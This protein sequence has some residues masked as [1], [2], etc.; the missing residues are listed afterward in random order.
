MSGNY[1][2]IDPR[3]YGIHIRSTPRASISGDTNNKGTRDK[4][5]D[6]SDASH[7]RSSGT[8]SSSTSSTALDTT[9]NP[10]QGVTQFIDGTRNGELLSS[11]TTTTTPTLSSTIA[12]H[13]SRREPATT[14]QQ[15]KH[16]QRRQRL[17]E[18]H[19]R[20]RRERIAKKVGHEIDSDGEREYWRAVYDRSMAESARREA[21]SP[22]ARRQED[23]ESAAKAFRSHIEPILAFDDAGVA[24]L[25]HYPLFLLQR[26]PESHNGAACRLPHCFDRIAPGQYRIAVSP[27]SWDPRGPDHYHVK[28]FE[29]LLDLSSLH[30]VA[31]FEPDRRKHIPDHGACCI[32]EEYMSRWRRRLRTKQ[33]S[34]S[35]TQQHETRLQLPH[36]PGAEPEHVTAESSRTQTESAAAANDENETA[37]ATES[38]VLG[39]PEAHTGG[40]AAL[41][42]IP[43]ASNG[44]TVEPD[45]WNLA[46]MLWAQIRHAEAEASERHNKLNDL[47]LHLDDDDDDDADPENSTTSPQSHPPTNQDRTWTWHI[48]QYLLADDHPEYDELERHALS[49]ALEDWNSDIMLANADLSQLTEAGRAAKEELGEMAIKRIKRYQNVRMPDYQ[50]LF[51]RG[52]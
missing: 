1:R 50:S 22:E 37:K 33:P 18:S 11:L 51:L 5:K 32:L 8:Q 40:S 52:R 39:P 10:A 29:H 25:Q 14:D 44:S 27:G 6:P 3:V 49:R 36:P 35:A 15:A 17:K 13:S 26:A 28:C 9:F 46:D 30:Y 16:E 48:T 31:R 4:D 42:Q 12:P 23:I 45:V 20:R 41:D 38:Q 43:V 24:H 47:F 21:L 19:N 34:D 7:N 2:A